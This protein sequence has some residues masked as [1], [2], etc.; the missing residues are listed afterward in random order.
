MKYAQ[1]GPTDVYSR[2]HVSGLIG[3]CQLCV[4]EQL[5]RNHRLFQQPNPVPTRRGPHWHTPFSIYLNHPPPPHSTPFKHRTPPP[6]PGPRR[7]RRLPSSRQL[8]GQSTPQ[9]LHTISTEWQWLSAVAAEFDEPMPGLNLLLGRHDED[10]VRC[11]CVC[12]CVCGCGTRGGR[13]AEGR[14]RGRGCRVV[15][16]GKV[17]FC[18]SVGKSNIDVQPPWDTI[19]PP[20]VALQPPSVTLQPPSVALQPPSVTL[21]PPSVAL[22]PP[23][24]TLQPPW[25]TIQPPSHSPPPPLFKDV[26]GSPPTTAPVVSPQATGC[27]PPPPPPPL[28]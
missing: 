20:S 7:A 3:P 10:E 28:R 26:L 13:R 11:V 22:Q 25:D 21:Q 23:S 9:L 24:V 2:R 27:A 16:G 18:S 14:V 19:Q 8:S 4:S 5:T 1:E 15:V 17:S 12:V 6:C